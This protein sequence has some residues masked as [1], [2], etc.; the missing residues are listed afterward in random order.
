M[1]LT[2][3]TESLIGLLE[4]EHQLDHSGLST[5]LGSEEPLPLYVA[6]D[7]VREK[8]LGRAVHLRGLIEFSSYCGRNCLYCGLRAANTKIS[9]FRMAPQEII[10][11]A[12]Q[13]VDRGLKTIVLQSGEDHFFSLDE[14]CRIVHGIKSMDV[15]VTLSIGERTE[16]EYAALKRAGADRYLLRIETTNQQLYTKLH[17]GMSYQ[18]RVRC[19]EDLKAL[20]YETGTGCLIGLPGQTREMLTADLIFFKKL[21]A[22]MIGMGPFIPCPGTP[23]ESETGGQV[24]TVLKMMALARLLLPEVNMPA[25]TALGIKDSAGYEKG[26]RCGANVIMPNIGGNQY[27]KRYAIY[28]GK[29][30]GPTNLEG[31][32]KRIKSLLVRMGRTVGQDYGNRKSRAL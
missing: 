15:A 26:L 10:A 20:G 16:R 1:K 6:A 29:G 2:P 31:D 7:R 30:E 5:L 18:K 28:P 22:D 21:D 9:R 8:Y 27:R 23:L 32:L 19:L 17:P 25:T 24:D 12:K 4:D 14:L 11:Y 13:G 3:E